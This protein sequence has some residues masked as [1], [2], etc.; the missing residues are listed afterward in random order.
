MAERE[1]VF[2]VT[3]AAGV[4][5]TAPVTTNLVFTDGIPVAV[6][7]VIPD[8]VAGLAG[9]RLS[10]AGVGILPRTKGAFFVGNDEVIQR[11]VS[12][13]PTGKSWQ[14]VGFNTDIYPHTF[15]VRIQLNEFP[16][17][18]AGEVLP[19]LIG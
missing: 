4:A 12:G 6:E 5:R 16:V 1:E 3:V 13:F 18:A 15:E 2:A 17:K 8:G 10:Y 9:A 7:L 11:E 19:V 14:F